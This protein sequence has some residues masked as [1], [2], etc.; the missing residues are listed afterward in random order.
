MGVIPSTYQLHKAIEAT[1]QKEL[2]TAIR[3]IRAML[4][5]NDWLMVG[6]FNEIRDPAERDGHGQFIANGAHKFNEVVQ[7][8]EELGYSGGFFTWSNRSGAHHTRT[9]LDRALGNS[10]WIAR[11][12]S[13]HPILK[14]GKNSGYAALHIELLPQRVNP[15]L[16]A[17]LQVRSACSPSTNPL[18]QHGVGRLQCPLYLSSTR[19]SSM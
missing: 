5:S 7:G 18:H 2:W 8:M 9:K 11:W 14:Y 1:K 4:E 10:Q 6:D 17:P 13:S 12:P 3:E 19:N 15:N 16:F